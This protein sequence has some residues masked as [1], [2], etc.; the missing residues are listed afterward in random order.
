MP[1]IWFKE[2]MILII[3]VSE[4]SASLEVI[5]VIEVNDDSSCDGFRT[6]L[7]RSYLL[8]LTSSEALT[9]LTSLTSEIFYLRN[10]KYIKR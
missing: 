6:L 5:E 3:P 10:L 8:S 2:R 9:S 1:V 4:V 7:Q